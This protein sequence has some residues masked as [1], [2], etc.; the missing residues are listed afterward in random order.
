MCPIKGQSDLLNGPPDPRVCTETERSMTTQHLATEHGYQIWPQSG[1]D[2]PQMGQIREIFRSDSVH[3]GPIWPT[4]G[5]NLV[6]VLIA[7]DSGYIYT[8]GCRLLCKHRIYSH[9]QKK[10]YTSLKRRNMK[11]DKDRIDFNIGNKAGMH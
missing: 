4:L 7:V 8:F 1:S 9:R 5:P 11:S 10:H 2:W 3:L 6:T